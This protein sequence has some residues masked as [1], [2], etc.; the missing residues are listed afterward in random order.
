MPRNHQPENHHKRGS[1]PAGNQ[2][3]FGTGLSST[4]LSSQRTN[5]HQQ[6]HPHQAGN[7]TRAIRPTRLPPGNFPILPGWLRVVKS[8]FQLS[9]T[10]RIPPRLIQ[11]LCGCLWSGCPADRPS[12]LPEARPGSLPASYLTRSVSQSQVRLA[13]ESHRPPSLVRRS[14]AP[15]WLSA[16]PAVLSVSR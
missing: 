13:G 3:N 5:T 9:R 12:S 8:Q 11:P 1:Q 14:P 2:T 7:P 15:S 10:T 16:F 6:N 4:L